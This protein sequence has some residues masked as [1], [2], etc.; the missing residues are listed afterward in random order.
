[1]LLLKKEI[2]DEE[3]IKMDNVL[4]ELK[5]QMMAMKIKKEEW[6]NNRSEINKRLN[7]WKNRCL[8]AE[9]KLEK[10]KKM[11]IEGKQAR[12]SVV[13]ELLETQKLV[14]SKHEE[15]FKKALRQVALLYNIDAGDKRFDVNKNVNKKTL[16][17]LVNMSVLDASEDDAKDVEEVVGIKGTPSNLSSSPKPVA[18]AEE[19]NVE[20]IE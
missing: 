11:I 17:Q 5:N 10:A 15:G 4:A 19:V 14:V 16:V 6:E 3:K 13:E 20:T 2:E 7:S 12:E 9:G 8:E 1:M 18:I